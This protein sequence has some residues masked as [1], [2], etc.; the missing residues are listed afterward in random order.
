MLFEFFFVI[1]SLLLAL[2]LEFLRIN[3]F[4][5]TQE[6]LFFRCGANF[7]FDPLFSGS[8]GSRL[9]V[10]QDLL[11]LAPDGLLHGQEDQEDRH[12]DAGDRLQAHEAEGD[13]LG[14]ALGLL[15][16]HRHTVHEFGRDIARPGQEGVK[17]RCG[18]PDRSHRNDIIHRHRHA[19]TANAALPFDMVQAVRK[20]RHKDVGAGEPADILDKLSDEHENHAFRS[21]PTESATQSV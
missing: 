5:L 4:T 15:R 14:H 8:K 2:H 19:V 21:H 20:E 18:D 13:D 1:Q 7:G 9:F 11:L 10:F 17:E 16:R 6:C 3:L 12:Y